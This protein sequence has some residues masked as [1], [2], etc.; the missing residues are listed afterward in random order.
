MSPGQLSWGKMPLSLPVF[1]FL[2]LP[3]CLLFTCSFWLS[4]SRPFSP[5]L[6][7]MHTC[8]VFVQVVYWSS[9]S[10]FCRDFILSDWRWKWLF[11]RCW[12][13]RES[14][15]ARVRACACVCVRERK[16]ECVY[17]SVFSFFIFFFLFCVFE[18]D[19]G[20]SIIALYVIYVCIYIKHVYIHV[21]IYQVR[22]HT[23]RERYAPA[24]SCMVQFSIH[25]PDNLDLN[26][27]C[28]LVIQHIL[29]ILVAQYFLVIQ[30]KVIQ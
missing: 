19:S 26:Q 3:P 9:T 30:R 12:C 14:V 22:G 16:K 25:I 28:I 20:F 27:K 6:S 10:A 23:W 24:L 5:S 17:V 15:C 4:W 13:V 2:C 7:C 18:D 29:S 21:Y 8:V 11:H 1:Y